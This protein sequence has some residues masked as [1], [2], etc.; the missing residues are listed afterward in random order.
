MA[1]DSMF[2]RSQ[3]FQNWSISLSP[4]LSTFQWDICRT[5]HGSKI[6]IEIQDLEEPKQLEA[7]HSWRTSNIWLQNLW[8]HGNLNSM[9]LI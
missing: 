1:K 9:L 2:L 4:F 6:H 8:E 7:E 3:V 5:W